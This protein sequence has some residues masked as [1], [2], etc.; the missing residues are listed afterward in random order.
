VRTDLWVA[1]VGLVL[2]IGALIADAHYEGACKARGG[3]W[4][5]DLRV[6][7]VGYGCQDGAPDGGR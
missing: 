5:E 4:V 2:L 6:G 3:R 1:L 7:W